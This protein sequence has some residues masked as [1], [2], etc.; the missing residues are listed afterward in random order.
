MT[1]F[2]VRFWCID[3]FFFSEKN[4]E[5][6]FNHIDEPF[7]R[8]SKGESEYWK[9]AKYGL[10]PLLQDNQ[11]ELSEV[12]CHKEEVRNELVEILDQKQRYGEHREAP[13]KELED[14]ERL[15]QNKQEDTHNTK[16]ARKVS[17]KREAATT[18]TKAVALKHLR[19]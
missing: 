18:L 11:Q 14:L 17:V 8:I 5:A 16:N 4:H 9:V 7:L 3:Y 13:M 2:D 15:Q 6:F 12:A 1:F 19:R 10:D